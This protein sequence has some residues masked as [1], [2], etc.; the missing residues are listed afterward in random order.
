MIT[1][2][3]VEPIN[4]PFSLTYFDLLSINSDEESIPKEDSL[5]KHRHNLFRKAANY[6]PIYYRLSDILKELHNGVRV[7]LIGS[8]AEAE[9]GFF[10][11]VLQALRLII[12][13]MD[14]NPCSFITALLSF[15]S[16]E[17]PDLEDNE[18]YA[19]LREIGR[20]TFSGIHWME[21][22]IG[23]NSGVVDSALLDNLFLVDDQALPAGSFEN[24]VGKALA[25][26]LYTILHP[27]FRSVWEA[28]FSNA[29]S[30]AG[31]YRKD[32]HRPCINSFGIATLHLSLAELKNY[33][34]YRL[35]YA[36]LYGERKDGNSDGFLSNAR[37]P[38]HETGEDLARRWLING[39]MSHPIFRWFLDT[40]DNNLHPLP[41]I[42]HNSYHLPFQIQLSQGIK[43]TLN[44]DQPGRLTQVQAALG[45]LKSRLSKFSERLEKLPV[46]NPNDIKKTEISNLMMAWMETVR[47]LSEQLFRWEKV[48]YE[49]PSLMS[50][51][52]N[53]SLGKNTPSIKRPWEQWKEPLENTENNLEIT[54]QSLLLTESIE[55][56]L[57]HE[58]RNTEKELQ[59]STDSLIS[60]SVID[61]GNGALNEVKKFYEDTIRPELSQFRNE[62]SQQ[63]L[64][65]R[66]RLGWWI[67]NR[68]GR[69]PVIYLICV[70]V[71]MSGLPDETYRY[72][73]EKHTGLIDTLH[74][75]AR[76]QVRELTVY[77]VGRDSWFHKRV[78]ASL[79]SLEPARKP[80]LAY[81]QDMAAHGEF[82]TVE[83]YLN[84]P[85][86]I[87]N[88][89]TKK[90]F[91][92]T[93]NNLLNILNSGEATRVTALGIYYNI[94]MEATE[95][96]R[97]IRGA[98]RQN[99][100]LHLYPQEQNAVI[101]ER[102][103][104]K[105]LRLD[106]KEELAPELT[107]AL[108]NQELVTLF[109]Q[110]L[111]CRL[112]D[113][114]TNNGGKKEWALK[115]LSNGSRFDALPLAIADD[116][117][118]YTDSLL[119]AL[120][121]F[122][123]ELPC[124]FKGRQEY[125][126]PFHNTHAEA[127]IRTLKETVDAIRKQPEYARKTEV[128]KTKYLARIKSQGTQNALARTF[129]FLLEV[130]LCD[131]QSGREFIR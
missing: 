118:N 100:N 120:T 7:I 106:N 84:G 129:A 25:E 101:Y 111:F 31:N 95:R 23:L 75:V 9:I 32:N 96:I 48:L 97:Q 56:I 76:A 46:Q 62:N 59:K 18:M 130:E 123:L 78:E 68:P 39:A 1:E 89:D 49:A 65:V 80:L 63:I 127:F 37:Q 42:H 105:L 52:S 73:P 17:P 85:E 119:S 38:I 90:I 79:A 60:Q 88:L 128:F 15:V 77:L 114:R 92:L 26:F 20:F 109:C 35:S 51:L 28:D 131:P 58:M 43:D 102:K 36:G 103:I 30:K 104:K 86:W 22:P 82:V 3:P 108:V 2:K 91:P 61:S 41:P 8:L 21:A 74:D 16:P 55:T 122:A 53:E 40:A 10:G 6:Q 117:D 121:R 98:Y 83:Q 54:Q 110:A 116:K 69:Q 4:T 126:N 12:K 94:P 57:L 107:L 125:N 50:N 115:S 93:P 66:E 33:I 44:S 72:T 13:N 45:W 34:T 113:L 24:G 67:D 87:S 70:P 112:I 27:S 81:D 71:D 5:R 29:I 64:R 124:E 14:H 11:D 99:G 19:A 47:D